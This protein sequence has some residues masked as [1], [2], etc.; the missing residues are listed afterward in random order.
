MILRNEGTALTIPLGEMDLPKEMDALSIAGPKPLGAVM[1]G[2]RPVSHCSTG[3]SLLPLAEH[4]Y[5][6]W[7]LEESVALKEV[8]A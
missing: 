6:A 3:A 4:A 8:G 1:V 5:P 7:L 2:H